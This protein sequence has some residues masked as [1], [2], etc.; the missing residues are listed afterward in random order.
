MARWNGLFVRV[1]RHHAHVSA[2]TVSSLNDE[3]TGRRKVSTASTF[4]RRQNHPHSTCLPGTSGD[5]RVSTGTCS[6]PR[7]PRHGGDDGMCSHQD[8]KYHQVG[9]HLS[10]TEGSGCHRGQAKRHLKECS[11]DRGRALRVGR[12][13]PWQQQTGHLLAGDFYGKWAGNQGTEHGTELN[14]NERFSKSKESHFSSVSWDFLPFMELFLNFE[15]F[16]LL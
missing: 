14:T 6:L 5:C 8:W 9:S 10:Q 13:T 7:D 2:K 4:K 11:K 3:E 12:K 16:F 15:G 1:M